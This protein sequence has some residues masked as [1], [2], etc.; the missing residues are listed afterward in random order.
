MRLI[1]PAGF[2]RILLL[3]AAGLSLLPC[4]AV[5]VTTIGAYDGQLRPEAVRG[6]QAIARTVALPLERAFAIGIPFPQLR[7]VDSFLDTV[8][9]DNPA[10]QQIAIDPAPGIMGAGYRRTAPGETGGWTV[11]VP[12][13]AAGRLV[14]TVTL[15]ERASVSEAVYRTVVRDLLVAALVAL[16]AGALLTRCLVG[17]LLA[18]PMEMAEQVLAGAMAGDL[19]R[20]AAQASA[21]GEIGALPAAVNR[22]V[23][24]LSDRVEELLIYAREVRV[25]AAGGTAA[26]RVEQLSNDLQRR[27]RL[28][29]AMVSVQPAFSVPLARFAGLVAITALV[30]QFPALSR[31][32]T[33]LGGA[34]RFSVVV[35]IL[36]ATL[37]PGGV[38]AATAKKAGR[39]L[40]LLLALGLALLPQAASAVLLPEAG[41]WA[42]AALGSLLPLAAVAGLTGMVRMGT[43]RADMADRSLLQATIPG[44]ACGC[45]LVGLIPYGSIIGGLSACLTVLTFLL[46]L[47]SPAAEAPRAAV[48]LA[49]LVRAL[50]RGRRVAVSVGLEALAALMFGIAA[51][52]LPEGSA[53]DAGADSLARWAQLTFYAAAAML[54]HSALSDWQGGPRGTERL[55]PAAIATA[56]LLLAALLVVPQAPSLVPVG[57]L[58]G[59]TNAWARSNARRTVAAMDPH[60]AALP[61]AAGFAGA[62]I[63]L[64]AGALLSIDGALAWLGAGPA[65]IVIVVALADPFVARTGTAID[66]GR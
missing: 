20:I 17:V 39:R 65:A 37:V 3:V 22:L 54:G 63:G 48:D 47:S 57:L 61:R 16:V 27:F 10:V 19:S 4:L 49:G 44:M 53:A 51:A 64:L 28:G 26:G 5:L 2:G 30:L 38:W 11:Q 35:G 46:L 25:V 56:A 60:A 29:Q 24:Q 34:G 1:L 33:G 62:A 32:A 58:T 42:G 9:S 43:G 13:E 6:L 12:L 31:L 40:T 21:S 36:L 45:G 18:A 7:G 8:L 14:A 15:T 23:R 55:Y 66:R 52:I 41:G 50:G 59:C